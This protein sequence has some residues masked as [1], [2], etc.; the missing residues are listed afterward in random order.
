MTPSP[1]VRGGELRGVGARGLTVVSL[2]APGLLVV[3]LVPA[4]PAATQAGRHDV[5]QACVALGIPSDVVDDA[6]VLESELVTHAVL[7][8]RSK[9]RFSVGPGD[10]AALRVHVGEDD[11]RLPVV[12]DED[13]Q[14]LG[15][16][17]LRLLQGMAPCWGVQS[18]PPGKVLWFELDADA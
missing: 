15:G 10:G 9:P 3:I 17:G 5:E 8:G 18:N 16:R 13:E 7:H 11:S 4:D 1:R 6:R 12:Q 2:P 14:S